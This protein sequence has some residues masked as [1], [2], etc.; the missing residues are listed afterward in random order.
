MFG[1]GQGITKTQLLAE[2]IFHHSPDAY[3]LVQDG[4]IT[5]CNLAMEQILVAARQDIIGLSPAQ[6]SPELQPDGQRS[7]TAAQAHLS[8]CLNE[9]SDRFEWLHQD[10]AGRPLPILVTLLRAT[11]DKKPSV[12]CFW[13]DI[14]EIVRSRQELD[15]ARRLENDRAA[16][17]EAILTTFSAALA[18]LSDG[19]LDCVLEPIEGSSFDP[20]VQS[21]K[22]TISVLSSIIQNLKDSADRVSAVSAELSDTTNNLARRTEQQALA[23]ELTA[24]SLEDITV[25]VGQSVD[26]AGDAERLMREAR[27][28]AEGST[29]MI[30]ETISAIQSIQRS[31]GEISN[32]IS[33]IDGIAFQTNLLA[34]NAGVEA[35]RAGEA[36]KGFAVV[37]QEVR[38][39]AQRSAGAAKEIK[40]L[41]ENSS[42]QIVAG[43]ELV[44]ST[45]AEL[46]KIIDQVIRLSQHVDAIVSSTRKQSLAIGTVTTAISRIDTGVQQTA[47]M[48][49]ETAASAQQLAVQAETMRDTAQAFKH[50]GSR[51]S[52]HPRLQHAK[53][54]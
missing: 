40:R 16:E 24:A 33:V 41:I 44:T 17:Q 45:G 28:R 6:L 35:A 1:I 29:Q 21:F 2:H 10:L 54:G 7:E 43:S 46:H 39:L 32:I 5:E 51:Q 53:M 26:R 20:L 50:D 48:V 38:D 27:A 47:A 13:Q 42:A 9:G 15:V 36:G 11:I 14:S 52:S 31:S 18:K 23:I 37:A 3:F 22:S 49:E 12:V 4:V 8:R 30:A 34:L 25:S 19:S